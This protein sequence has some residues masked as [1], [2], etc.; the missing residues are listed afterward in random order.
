MSP[1]RHFFGVHSIFSLC[2][3]VTRKSRVKINFFFLVESSYKK[4]NSKIS[5]GA[6]SKKKNKAKFSCIRGPFKTFFFL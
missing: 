4:K 6:K 1:W 5:A 3:S 2:W